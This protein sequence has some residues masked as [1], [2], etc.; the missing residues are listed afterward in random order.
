MRVT[1]SEIVGLVPL[2]A[3]LAAGDYFLEAQGRTTAVPERDRVKAAVVSLG[4]DEITPFDPAA[5]IVEYRFRGE[6]VGLVHKT[7]TEFTDELSKDSPRAR[8][9]IGGCTRGCSL[10]I[11]VI[12]GRIAHA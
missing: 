12:D 5:K 7:L 3:M 10:G 4:L 9:W 6:P 11:V 1:G 2:E 8:W